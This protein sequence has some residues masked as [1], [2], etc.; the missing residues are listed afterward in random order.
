MPVYR[1]IDEIIFPPPRE[2]EPDGLLAVGGD[3][4]PQRLLEAYR[5]GIF[6]WYAEGQPILW[7]SPDPRFV[8]EPEAFHVSRRL[9]Q[10]LSR[11]VFKVTFD[12][13]FA[14]VIRA[15]ASVQR[16]GQSGTWIT[17]EME[18]AYI[19]LHELG[20]AHS[21]ESWSEEALVGGVYGVALGRCFFAESMFFR[22]ANASKVA[23]ALLVER[24]KSWGFEMIDAQVPT[25]HMARLGAREIRRALFLKRLGR[26]LSH[27][28][29][30]GKWDKS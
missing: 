17:P 6:P 27:P 24:L 26:A 2:A 15:C 23:L 5:L 22:A 19:R 28:T 4:S 13:A 29:L 8:L 18:A 16:K 9:R 30:R 14:E 1:L 11:G 20:Y 3:L 10:T 25:D 21:A 7:W 12:R